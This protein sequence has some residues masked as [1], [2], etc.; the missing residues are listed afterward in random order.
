MAVMVADMRDLLGSRSVEALFAIAA[1][2]YLGLPMEAVLGFPLDPASSYLSELAAKDQPHGVAFRLADGIGAVLVLVGVTLL[3]ARCAPP[4]G[5]PPRGAVYGTVT[6][7]LFAVATIADVIF[8]M[9]CATSA[10]PECARGDAEHTLG[11]SHQIHLVSSALALAAV[12]VSAVLLSAFATRRRRRAHQGLPV[13]LLV[14]AAVLLVS[15]VTV[16]VAAL[17]GATD[18]ALPAGAGYL[19]RVQTVSV[20]LYLLVFPWVL[21]RATAAPA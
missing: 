11:L 18:G 6:L 16:S 2:L 1:V 5:A 14:L 9:A 15:S 7:A 17:A 10:D 13:A 20:C 3:S 19:Q 8:P 12:N 4:R 21:A